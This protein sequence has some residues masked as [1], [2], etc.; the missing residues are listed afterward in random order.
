MEPD[1]YL[2][3]LSQVAHW[4]WSDPT[5][6]PAIDDPAAAVPIFLA[7]RNPGACHICSQDHEPW[8][9]FRRYFNIRRPD[10]RQWYRDCRTCGQRWI[11]GPRNACQKR[12]P[13]TIGRRSRPTADAAS[14]SDAD[15]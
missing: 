7:S 8:L 11:I 3:L 12:P 1:R 2:E 6:G 10:V 14:D 13:M 5:P 9:Y 4:E 15:Q